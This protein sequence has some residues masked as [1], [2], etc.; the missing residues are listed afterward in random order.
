MIYGYAFDLSKP[1][2][3]KQKCRRPKR[4]RGKTRRFDL[5]RASKAI[6]TE[7]S[8]VLFNC[9]TLLLDIGNKLR[10]SQNTHRFS[11][12][13]VESRFEEWGKA[14]MWIA[15]FRLINIVLSDLDKT[16]SQFPEIYLQDIL[17]L[18][19]YWWADC[20][21]QASR[22]M[23][24]V[25]IHVGNLFSRLRSISIHGQT[26]GRGRASERTI[27]LNEL[28][29]VMRGISRHGDPEFKIIA[30]MYSEEEKQDVLN[31]LVPF[32]I[33]LANEDIAFETLVQDDDENNSYT[34]SAVAR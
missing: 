26:H 16:N 1:V 28:L 9:A 22:P 21:A 12:D 31:W 15:Q 19:S 17:V 8:W 25:E 3:V 24:L 10:C 14:K 5:L 20:D 18:L 23:R 30:R 6:E 13:C 27:D 33:Q 7:A 2:T 32:R 29:L 11:S 34:S 4:P